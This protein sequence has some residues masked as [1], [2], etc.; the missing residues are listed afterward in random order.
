MRIEVAP[1]SS[2][3]IHTPGNARQGNGKPIAHALD[4]DAPS[5]APG[6]LSANI[7]HPGTRIF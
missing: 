3:I 2:G 7:E 5:A 1:T 6:C 4:E